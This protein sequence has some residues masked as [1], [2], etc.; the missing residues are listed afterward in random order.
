MLLHT[1]LTR[2]LDNPDRRDGLHLAHPSGLMSVFG[3]CLA[4]MALRFWLDRFGGIKRDQA[5]MVE[6]CY[7]RKYGLL[8]PLPRIIQGQV[9]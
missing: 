3:Q 4:T 1:A 5:V 6:C 2:I 7:L 9:P 8:V